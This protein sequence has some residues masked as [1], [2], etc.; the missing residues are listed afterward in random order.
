MWSQNDGEWSKVVLEQF[1]SPI[2]RLSWD[3][4]GNYL[5]ACSQDGLVYLFNDSGDGSW[6]IVAQTN[7]EG[8]VENLKQ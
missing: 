2:T 6:N 7:I 3:E 8:A 1:N 4:N 5:S